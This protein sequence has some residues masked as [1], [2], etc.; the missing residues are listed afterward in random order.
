[1]VRKIR[2]GR[3]EIRTKLYMAVMSAKQHNPVIR[4]HYNQLIQRGKLHKV[5]MVACM[6]KMLTML[7]KQKVLRIWQILA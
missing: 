6:R 2:G 3:T 5:A 7:K 1:M 4:T